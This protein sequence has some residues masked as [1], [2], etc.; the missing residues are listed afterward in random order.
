MS[1]VSAGHLPFAFNAG[2]GQ[3]PSG[4]A[5]NAIKRSPNYC[6]GQFRNQIP[7]SVSIRQSSKLALLWDFLIE[8]RPFARP[9]QPLP[10]IKTD[11]AALMPEQEVIVWLGHS[12]W[13]L[14]LAGKR[15]LIDPVFSDYAAP[16]AFINKAFPG[17]YPWHAAAMP[18]IDLLVISHDHYDHLDYATICALLPK[19]R[20]AVMPLGVG[21]HLRYWGMDCAI[22]TEADWNQQVEISP[23][24][25]VHLLPARHFSGRSLRRNQTLWGS[26]M[27]V[28]PTRKVYYSGDSG[29]GPHFSAIGE[30][31]GRV[32]FA[33]MENGQYDAEWRDIHMQPEETARAAADLHA[34]AVLPGH[35]GRFVLARH[36]WNEP[37]QRLLRASQDK[38]YRLLTPVQGEPVLLADANQQFHVWWE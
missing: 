7:P 28:T 37:Y 23:A 16:Y 2:F 13:Y 30:Q 1:V 10:L 22:I 15:I 12:S 11:L 36:R 25:T 3:A 17:E 35:A 5:L 8:K 14:Q 24:L 19:V 29:Y 20:Q 9:T 27:F 34:A 21:S 6:R 4:E 33:I 38:N 18:E 32:D 31:F 26:F